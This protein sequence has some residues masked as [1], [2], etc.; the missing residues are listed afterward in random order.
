MSFSVKIFVFKNSSLLCVRLFLN[1]RLTTKGIVFIGPL[2]L[3][4]NTACNNTYQL[5]VVSM[6]DAWL[7]DVAEVCCTVY[8]VTIA[9]DLNTWAVIIAPLTL[10]ATYCCHVQWQLV[11]A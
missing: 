2:S 9:A 11:I 3:C 7:E 8:A 4:N 5:Y 6:D 1:E 10:T